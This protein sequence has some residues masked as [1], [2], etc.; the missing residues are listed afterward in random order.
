MK[1]LAAL[2]FLIAL[3][4]NAQSNEK[5]CSVFTRISTILQTRHYKPKP[6]DDSLSVYVYNTVME[7][8][9]DNHS[10][11]LQD[12]AT[13]LEKHKYKIDD[14]LKS[15]D[16][17]FFTDFI[18][19]Y[20]K[21]LER[22]KQ[23]V[24]EIS[25]QP[26]S[27]NTKDTIFYSKKNF[28]FHTDPAKI[29]NFLRKKITYDI[30]E[31]I[32]MLSKNKDSLKQHLD[33]LF[34]L[35]Q[36]KITDTYLCRINSL[37]TPSEGFE[38]SIYNRFYSVFCSYF[39]PHSTYFNYNE[40]QSFVSS[41]STEN[42]SLGLYVSQNEKEEIIVEEVV[43]GGPAYGSK[44]VDKGDKLIKLA[45]NGTE[46]TV[47]CAAMETINNIVY[48]DT[49]K[50]VDLT[51][52]KKDGSLYTVTL[53]K[54]VMK[55]DDHSVYSFVLGEGKDKMGYIK[56][57]SFYTA[58]DNESGSGVADDVAKEVST[59]KKSDIKGL[60]IDLQYNGGGS[61]D[62][63]IRMAGMFINYGPVSIV[64][65]KNQTYNTIRDYNRGMLY[66]GPMVVLVNGFT[67]S[68]SEFFAGVMQDYNRAVIVGSTTVGKATM[69]T[70]LPL[71]EK[72]QTDFVKVTIDKFYR[73]S[74]KSSQ[75]T[76]IVPDVTLPF[77]FNDMLPREK[78]MPTAIKNDSI[79]INLR[80]SKMA[81]DA[82]K[83]A[84]SL[85][86]TRTNTNKTLNKL[87]TINK[88]V[89]ELYKSDKKPLPITFDSVYADTHNMDKLWKEITTELE[90][91]NNLKVTAA[92]GKSGSADSD[93]FYKSVNEFK[94]KSIK[95]DPYIFESI[96]ILKDLSNYKSR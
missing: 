34:P 13:L 10:L 67:A 39:D 11:F 88:E 84:I 50:M 12:E 24:E 41:I 62:E 77:V 38:N 65:D 16:C 55:A 91:E 61:M 17:T 54:Q 20:K 36:A 19:T 33:K 69:Q 78:T 1:K 29:K 79:D 21:A 14:Y 44:K 32:S 70:I 76:G 93:A 42:Y 26:L 90:K 94:V 22:N 2:A 63:V 87:I 40:K 51:L 53:E 71:D 73:V 58:M 37:L 4:A 56:I 31:D 52:R 28:P 47:S 48:S 74:G 35:S 80:F 8:L 45:V 18:V 46:Y 25:K 23:F 43:P 72:N 27:Y 86:K 49:Y 30:L 82:I 68:A 64:T 83:K 6:V 66:N 7:Q 59:L 95:A 89:G 3:Q 60:I 85:S 5:A 15:G 92:V 57:P 9:D 96:N 81:D 75:Y